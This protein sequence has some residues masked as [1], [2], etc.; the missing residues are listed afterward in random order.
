V[1]GA[2]SG[3]IKD[4]KD[5]CVGNDFL[6]ARLRRLVPGGGNAAEAEKLLVQAEFMDGF[7]PLELLEMA[8]IALQHGLIDQGIAILTRL[9]TTHPT[10]E[11]GWREHARVLEMLARREDLLSLRFRAEAHME[12]GRV[13]AIFDRAVAPIVKNEAENDGSTEAEFL[14]FLDYRRR[15]SNLE[16]YMELFQGREDCFARQ[17]VD[18]S[19]EASGYVPVRRPFTSADLEDHLSGKKTYGIY[20]LRSDET[21]SVGVLDIDLRKRYRS[22]GKAGVAKAALRSEI[23]FVFKQIRDAAARAG[24][25][26]LVEFSGG[27]GYHVWFPAGKPV[28]A[29]T[30]RRA[31]S[32]LVKD[33]AARV[34]FFDIEVFPKQDSLSGKGLGNLVKLPLGVHR[35]SGKRSYFLMAG[36]K[37]EERQLALVSDFR[38]A[39]AARFEAIAATANRAEVVLHPAVASLEK[40]FPELAAVEKGCRIISRVM[41]SL[42][43]GQEPS[44]RERK[45]LLGTIGHLRHGREMLH[46][47]LSKAPGYNRPLLDYEI[48]RLRGTPL[49]CRRIHGLL[50]YG[51]GG[52]DCSFESGKGAYSHPLLHLPSWRDDMCAPKGERITNLQD[53][54]VNLK[55]ALEVVDRYLP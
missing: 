50:G 11:E 29:A 9:N 47:L 39:P 15:A 55:A 45:V 6:L 10:F 33:I 1:S 36:G 46:H 22:D 20:L 42:M 23:A 53:A 17:W 4:L 37:D 51:D 28:P 21:V 27:K 30:M 5:P 31:L 52:L 3:R 8:R 44:E 34:E 48:S 49:G 14:P 24:L 13:A 41:R 16:R 40:R 26:F 18:R 35:G 7:E 19:K 2:R 43:A 32:A 38:P 25:S 54:L 12:R